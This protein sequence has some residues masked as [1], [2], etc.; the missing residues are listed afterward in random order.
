MKRTLVNLLKSVLCIGVIASCL[1]AAAPAQ[2]QDE[3]YPPEAYI[4]T[5]EPAYFEGR[6]VYWYG[7]Y[8]YYRDGHAWHHYASEPYYLRNYRG[9]HPYYGGAHYYGY[10]RA[11]G[12]GYHGGGYRRR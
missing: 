5:Y 7:G 3:D 1:V 9:A 8:W 11:H 2:A 10:G 6:P 4:A 12:G